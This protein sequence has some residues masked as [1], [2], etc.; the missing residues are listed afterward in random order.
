MR[1]CVRELAAAGFDPILVVWDRDR[2]RSPIERICLADTGRYSDLPRGDFETVGILARQIERH[3]R[4]EMP[5]F[6]LDALNLEVLTPFQR[7]VLLATR[8]IP[9]GSVVSY[10]QLAARIGRPKAARAVGNALGA[11]PFPIA[12]PCHRVIRSDGSLGGFGSGIHLKQ[13]LLD[14]ENA[15]ICSQTPLSLS[16]QSRA[17]M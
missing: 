6:D 14:I 2:P 3:L 1:L 7:R 12:I 4:G 11:N 8:E 5:A 13:R 17:S 15:L 16:R 10:G 9:Y